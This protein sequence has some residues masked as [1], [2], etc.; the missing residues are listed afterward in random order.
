[1]QDEHEYLPAIPVLQLPPTGGVDFSLSKNP[2]ALFLA[3]L[4][5]TSRS[6]M[7]Y[8]LQDA[9]DRFGYEDVPITEIP[10][11]ELEPSH[12][13]ALMAVLREDDYAPN[14]AALYVAA[15]RGV[16]NEAWLQQQISH[17]RLAR[18]RAIKP[19]RGAR[20]PKGKNLKRSLIRELMENCAND[21]RPQGI[22]DAAIIAILYGSGM[23]KT[24]SI[25]CN[26]EDV[27]FEERTI[28]VIAKGNK[29][30]IKYAPPWAFDKLKAWLE[31]RAKVTPDANYLFN[32]IRKGGNITDE[33]LTKHAIYYIIKRRGLEAG[34][35]MTPHDFR[36]SFITRV[37]D[38]H[39]VSIAQKLAGHSS[40]ATT[41]RYDMRD[42][43]KKRTVV[44][45]LDL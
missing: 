17:E 33:R 37:I 2:V 45:R 30:M 35:S 3:R 28:R 21:E 36:R 10:W 29:E 22:R 43:E 4:S 42:E 26:L 13:T 1:M 27:N 18:I 39:D 6:T 16:M 7:T 31:C 41:A 14:T 38:E 40:I 9:A 23:R 15:I 44:D 19:Y 5:P 24:E 32:R 25:N 11:H 20:L 8:V 12:V 34:V